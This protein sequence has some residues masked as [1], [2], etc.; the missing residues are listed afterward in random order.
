MK[1]IGYYE[2]PYARRVGITLK[3][4]G[5]AF[6]HLPLGTVADGAAIRAYN[7]TGRIP[8]LVLEDG[9]VLI[10]SSVII[11]H[12]DAVAGPARALTPPA[13]PQRRRVLALVA[14]ALAAA[15]KYVAAY[16]EVAKRPASHLW[17]PWRDHLE[18]QVA[19][20]LAA[21]DGAVAGPRF[22]GEAI[23]QA[24]VTTVAAVEAMR[25]DMAHLAPPGRYK[26]LDALIASL[27]GLEAFAATRP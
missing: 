23:T 26:R 1:L 12:L 5:M 22:F 10:D 18:G 20:A 16:Y 17:A 13:G 27:A 7:P 24:E 3:L 15:D 11:D 25:F 2:S 8:A 9:E 19:A 21:L 4:Y 6:E 14:L